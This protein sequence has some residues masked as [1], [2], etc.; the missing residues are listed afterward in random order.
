MH[1]TGRAQTKLSRILREPTLHFFALAAALFLVHRLV[2]TD[3]RTIVITPALKADILRRFQDQMGRPASS[4][5]AD[6]VVKTWKVDEALYRE[7]LR[8]GL[9]REDPAVRSALINKVRER[10]LLE[11]RI[12]EPSEADLER[13]LAQHRDQYESPWIYEHEY[14]VFPKSQ[15]D[16]E[17]ERAAVE[18]QLRAGATPASLGLRSTAANVNRERIEREF[19]PATADA[20]TKLP[21]G[22]WH[23]VA[24]VDRLVLVRMIAKKGGMP[25]P[26]MLHARVLADWQAEK[27]AKAVAAK[28][29]AIVER[30]RF[31]EPSR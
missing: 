5:E 18:R 25:P 24:S 28:A 22:G 4:A 27:T 29:H 9:D 15:P 16:A 12:S 26:E 7:A 3:P 19:G 30:Y 13:Y 2:V 23:E 8:E 20:I 1:H 17:Q 11:A 10:A 14:V 31:E 21:I 6:A